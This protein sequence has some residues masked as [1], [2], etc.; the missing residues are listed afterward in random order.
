MNIADI[1][2]NPAVRDEVRSGTDWRLFR[3]VLHVFLLPELRLATL[4][5]HVR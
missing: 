4:S 5:V 1:P 2:G 3:R